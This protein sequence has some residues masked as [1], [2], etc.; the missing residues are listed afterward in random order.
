MGAPKGALNKEGMICWCLFS[1][2][3]QLRHNRR[4]YSHYQRHDNRTQLC[5]YAH[6]PYK[7]IKVRNK[8]ANDALYDGSD[9]SILGFIAC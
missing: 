5:R 6:E 7:Q 4:Q 3:A 9:K 8:H 2:A 1:F